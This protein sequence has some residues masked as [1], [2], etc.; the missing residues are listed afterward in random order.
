MFD[1]IELE[2]K[3]R[4]GNKTKQQS[5]RGGDCEGSLS[6]ILSLSGKEVLYGE[7]VFRIRVGLC[8]EGSLLHGETG[9]KHKM[10]D[11][12]IPNCKEEQRLSLSSRRRLRLS[13]FATAATRDPS[14]A[15]GKCC[16]KHIIS[17]STIS[18]SCRRM[19]NSKANQF[20]LGLSA[21]K[22]VEKRKKILS[23][24]LQYLTGE[25]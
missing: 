2:D 7:L 18:N 20:P 17:L 23:E 24:Y 4:R 16:N 1:F 22:L 12:S 14:L 6:R 3:E 9:K 11:I 15:R 5:T 19:L 21:K 8:G 13:L 10:G 25:I